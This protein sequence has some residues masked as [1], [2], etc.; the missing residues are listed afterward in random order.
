MENTRKVV[1]RRKGWEERPGSGTVDEILVTP[2]QAN[3][4][5]LA[6]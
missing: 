3:A 6:S 2:L 1:Q 4:V 5:I